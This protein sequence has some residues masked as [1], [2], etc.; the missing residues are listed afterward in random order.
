MSRE[1]QHSLHASIETAVVFDDLPLDHRHIEALAVQLTPQVKAL[2]AQA[3]AD[4]EDDAPVQYAIVGT[5]VDETAGVS[6]TTY[7]QCTSRINVLVDEDSPAAL[8]AAKF[9]SRQPDVVATDVPSATYLG[10]TVRPQSLHAWA[11]WVH[12]L[13]LDPSA[14]TRQDNAVYGV[15]SVGRV[16]VHVCG[17]GVPELLTDTA[18]AR[19]MGL[20]AEADR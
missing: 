14:L 10:L 9:R 13:A 5:E 2:I 1:L 12:R 8:L 17:D 6:T 19:L 4:A 16:A 11:W 3:V 18:A 15:G 7:A 20:L